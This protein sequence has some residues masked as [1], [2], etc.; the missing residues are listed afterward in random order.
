MPTVPT[1]D[2]FQAAPT[3]A[4]DV[5]FTGPRGPGAGQIAGEQIQNLGR[6]VSGAGQQVARVAMAMEE[7]ANQVRVNDAV[8]QARRAAQDLAYGNPDAGVTGYLSLKGDQALTRPNGQSLNAEYGDK[9]QARLGEIAAT[10]GNDVQRRQF[11]MNASDLTAQFHGQVE[12]HFLGEFRSHAL[13]VQ[14]GTI[15]LASDDAKRNWNNPDLIAP[16]LAAAKAA[17][18]EKGRVSG[19]SAAQTDAAL[20]TTTGK[21]HSD[22]VMA[23]LENGNPAYAVSYL[24][25]NKDQMTADDILR[26]QGHVNQQMW[27]G[28]AQTAVQGATSEAMPKVAPTSFD[29]MMNITVGSESG[30]MQFSADG[31]TPLTSPKNAVGIAQVLRTTGP[32]AAKLAGMPWDENRFN[33]DAKY[34]RALGAAYLQAQLQK[35][36][37]PAKAWA[38]YNAGPGALDKALATAKANGGDWLTLM[39]KET[40]SYV[41]KNMAQLGSDTGGV[42]ARPTELDFVNAALAKLPEGAHPQLVKMTRE[43]AISQFGVINKTLNEQ[44]DAALAN[45]QRIIASNPGMTVEKLP[46]GIL[47]AVR[48]Y[49]PGKVDDLYRFSKALERG[50]T[51]TNLGRYNDIVTNMDQY[52][53]LSDAAWNMLQSELSPS[54]FKH[55][56]KE[57]ATYQNSAPDESVQG[58]NRAAVN[59]VLNQNLAVMHIPT[60]PG[61]DESARERLGGIQQFVDQSVLEAQRAL[62][63]KMTPAELEQH[64]NQLFAADVTFRHSVLGY[65]TGTS[66][67]KLMAMQIKDLPDGAYEGI[68]ADL[69][70]S[71][72]AAPSDTDILNVYRR[73]HAVPARKR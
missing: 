16:S 38:A 1:Y 72:N 45:A 14:D 29:R 65:T 44:G 67:Q 54:D 59:R 56:S 23:A 7:Q 70:A 22:V 19:W 57:R 71:G 26:V 36:G 40:Q 35:Y 12:S 10:L 8:N 15:N 33:T 55:L 66:S 50:D 9:L 48:Q 46:P 17:V 11:A 13:S 69:V 61:K 21:V 64:I 63:K 68:K 5:A 37:D 4:P 24:A 49:A 39:P 58:L 52:A 32:E 51:T 28:L 43:A 34:N 3:L 2:N 60:N 41:A 47:D 6:S 73:L 25:R 53:N 27:M 62:G 42:G 30:G 18:I 20:L 31:V